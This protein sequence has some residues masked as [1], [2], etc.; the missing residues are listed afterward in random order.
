[1]SYNGFG[2]WKEYMADYQQKRRE[3]L[4]AA[5]ICQCG[6]YPVAPGKKTCLNC[7]LRW[8]LKQEENRLLGLCACGEMPEPNHKTCYGCL[9]RGKS[10]RDALRA[11][12]ICPFCHGRWYPNRF[13]KCKTCAERRAAA[14]AKGKCIICRKRD[15]LPWRNVCRHC[16]GSIGSAP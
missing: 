8:N 2:S 11:R 4:A 12:G 9:Q 7:L 14:K 16:A 5:G 6:R 1:M 3:R 13:P 15:P 10:Y